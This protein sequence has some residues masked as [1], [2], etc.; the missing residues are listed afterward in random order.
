MAE[1]LRVGVA[2]L[3]TVVN[4]TQQ[5]E[6]VTAQFVDLESRIATARDSVAR[7]REFL[8]RTTNV[9]E[10]AGLEAELTR[11]ETELEQ[12]VATQQGLAARAALATAIELY[13]AM[14]MTFWLPQAEAALAEVDGH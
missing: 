9:N 10:L 1:A 11:R 5:A 4:Q 12:L 8:G 2:G 13:R 6:D 3:G 14:E 7:V